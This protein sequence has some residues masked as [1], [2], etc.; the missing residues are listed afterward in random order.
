M[1]E[2]ILNAMGAKRDSDREA[3]ERAGL[4]W[5]TQMEQ[6]SIVWVGWLCRDR[7]FTRSSSVRPTLNPL[8]T[9]KVIRNGPAAGRDNTQ[10]TPA[11]AG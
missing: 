3:H 6:V 10:S 9:G 11:V 5:T 7:R 2:Q 1:V 4:R 8:F